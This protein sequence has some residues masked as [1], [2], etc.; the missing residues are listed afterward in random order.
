M[1]GAALTLGLSSFALAMFPQ[2]RPFFFFDPTRP[3]ETMDAA[4]PAVASV[5]WRFAHYLALIGFVLL[6]CVLPAL[7]ARLS[8]AGVETRSRRATLLC[9]LGVALVLPTMG[10]ELYAFPAISRIYL[11]GNV[12]IAPAVSLIYIGGATLVMLLGLLLLAIGAIVLATAVARSRALP[13]WAAIVYAIGL[14]AW[15][16]LLPPIVRVV[17]GL[18]IGVGG[19]A[20]AWALRRVPPPPEAPGFYP[21]ASGPQPVAPQP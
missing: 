20:L 11:A 8:A 2:F 7:H 14:A 18:L 21:H 12:S 10:V 3:M 9:T 16:P 1:R 4:A 17:D 13:R 15:C 6:L 5:P 19:I